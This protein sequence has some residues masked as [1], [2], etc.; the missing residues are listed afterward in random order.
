MVLN[1][2]IILILQQNVMQDLFYLMDNAGVLKDQLL[3]SKLDH[4]FV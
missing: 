1:I 4:I 3:I 2:A